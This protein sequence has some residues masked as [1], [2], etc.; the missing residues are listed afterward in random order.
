MWSNKTD[1][2]HE[3]KKKIMVSRLF[4]DILLPDAMDC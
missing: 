1:I 4:V 2:K 3:S